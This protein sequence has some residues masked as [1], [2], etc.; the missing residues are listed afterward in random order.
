MSSIVDPA[1]L[2]RADHKGP[3]PSYP[4]TPGGG[5]ISGFGDNYEYYF[6]ALLIIMMV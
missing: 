6:G 1:W 4:G 2:Q 5:G 3:V